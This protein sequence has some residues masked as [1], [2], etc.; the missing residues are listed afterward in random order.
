MKSVLHRLAKV[1]RPWSHDSMLYEVTARCNLRCL[2]CYNVWKDD[3]GYASEELDTGHAFKL[4][5]KAIRD[6]RCR[7]FTF[8]G[9]EPCLRQDLEKLVSFAAARCRH[10]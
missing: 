4:I 5:D 6:S 2:H 3:V 7:Q 9:G 10:V 8:T 1:L